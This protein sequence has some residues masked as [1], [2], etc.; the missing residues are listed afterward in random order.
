M[1]GK[2]VK[3]AAKVSIEKPGFVKRAKET[4]RE[5]MKNGVLRG[6]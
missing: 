6:Q 5:N 2:S 1:C 4:N 3:A